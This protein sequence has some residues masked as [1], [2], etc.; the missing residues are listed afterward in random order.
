[1]TKVVTIKHYNTLIMIPIVGIV[2][3]FYAIAKHGPDCSVNNAKFY[4]VISGAFIQAMTFVGI[5]L[6]S[7][8]L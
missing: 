4:P 7:I 5:I 6:A 1:M 3:V 2:T 8:L